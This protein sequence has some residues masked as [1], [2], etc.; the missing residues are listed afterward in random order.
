[1]SDEEDAV[2][3]AEEETGLDPT[4]K[5]KDEEK[6]IRQTFTWRQVQALEAVFEID[7]MPRQVCT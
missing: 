3:E 5:S 7:P 1:M 6:R 2:N 4:N